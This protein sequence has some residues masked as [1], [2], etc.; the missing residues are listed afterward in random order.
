LLRQLE[1]RTCIFIEDYHSCAREK[2]CLRYRE[3]KE[4]NWGMI[5]NIDKALMIAKRQLAEFVYDAVNLE[6]LNFSLPEIQTLLD[7]IT[8]GG[9]KLSDQQVAINQG[10]AWKKIFEWVS[11]DK[12]EITNERV[13]ELHK[14]AGKEEALKWGEFRTGSVYIA[15]TNYTPPHHSELEFR[16]S[17]MITHLEKIE[18]VYDKAIHLFL[19]MARTQFF[20]DVN[21]RMGRFIMNGFLLTNG[22][23][24][25]NLPAKRQLEFNTKML[26]FYESGIQE[27]MNLFLRS[28][29]DSRII[30][31]MNE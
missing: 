14:I 10:D 12:F 29:L 11:Q 17:E 6:G 16:F 25:I 18:D 26:S 8:V 23:P 21:K 2:I 15:G 27:E 13:C 20:Y 28:C 30:Q 22:F 19:T 24:A 7:G 9:H 1:E 31:I 3:V 4:N 5:S